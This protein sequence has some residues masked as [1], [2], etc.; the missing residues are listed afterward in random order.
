MTSLEVRWCVKRSGEGAVWHVEGKTAGNS[1]LSASPR[2]KH[3]HRHV[4]GVAQVIKKGDVRSH[5]KAVLL[6]E[7]AGPSC[8]ASCHGEAVPN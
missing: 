6:V 8:A 2:V 3:E 4:R 5:L 1:A 7:D